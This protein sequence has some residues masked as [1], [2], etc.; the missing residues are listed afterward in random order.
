MCAEFELEPTDPHHQ[1]PC[2]RRPPAEGSASTLWRIRQAHR[3]ESYNALHANITLGIPGHRDQVVEACGHLEKALFLLLSWE[4]CPHRVNSD[5]RRVTGEPSNRAAVPGNPARWFATLTEAFAEAQPRPI[6]YSDY[7]RAPSAWP[8]PVPPEESAGP[9][10]DPGRSPTAH[11]T[12]SAGEAN[13]HGQPSGPTPFHSLYTGN[14]HLTDLS[15]A[16]DLGRLLT[17]GSTR[18]PTRL[19][20]HSSPSRPNSPPSCAG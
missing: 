2:R 9:H 14:A 10:N 4:R 8:G 1:H 17:R 11:A 3:A 7:A 19:H 20:R 15:Q 13:S 16:R 12:R 18:P 5:P 6:L